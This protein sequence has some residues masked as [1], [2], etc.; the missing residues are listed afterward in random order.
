M[1]PF[2]QDIL[3]EIDYILLR[4]T[5]PDYASLLPLMPILLIISMP[6]MPF[7]FFYFI[8]LLRAPFIR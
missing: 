6:M 3:K 7:I 2:R 4:L 1:P 8:F 5:P